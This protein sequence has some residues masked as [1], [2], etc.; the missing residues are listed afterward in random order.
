MS[1]FGFDASMPGRPEDDQFREGPTLGGFEYEDELLMAGD[2]EEEIQDFLATEK[3]ADV[4]NADTFGDMDPVATAKTDD[5]KAWEKQPGRIGAS[6]DR[7][8]SWRW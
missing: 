4:A 6:V 8:C 5:A 7:V 1:F 3:E 2:D